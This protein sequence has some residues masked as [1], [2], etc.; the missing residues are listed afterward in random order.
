MN[1]KESKY[2]T[3]ILEELHVGFEFES[4]N[5]SV[6]DGVW[7]K[8]EFQPF[9]KGEEYYTP[10]ITTLRVKYLDREDIESLGFTF[11]EWWIREEHGSIYIN[12]MYGLTFFNGTKTISIWERLQGDSDGE[13]YFKGTIKNKSELKRVLKMI[14]V[15]S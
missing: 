9:V 15:C 8:C 14:G 2:Y 13:T 6:N 1:K 12:N 4:T 5:K 3:P 7:I 11:K 10:D